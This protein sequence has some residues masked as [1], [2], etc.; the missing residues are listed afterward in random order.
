MNNEEIEWIEPIYNRIEEDVSNVQHNPMITN[1]IGCYNYIDLNRIENDTHYCLNYMLEHNIISTAP[2]MRF[3]TDWTED[4]LVLYSDIKRIIGN[5]DLLRS[6]SNPQIK[7]GL[8][9]IYASA[10]INYLLANAIEKCL[11]IMHD[12][13]ELPINYFYMKLNNGI[14]TTIDRLDGETETINSDE[15]WIAENEIAHITGIAS[16][17]DIQYK[18]FTNWSGNQEDLQYIGNTQ[19]Q[20]T[21]YQGQ[22][23]NVEFTANFRTVFPRTLSLTNAYISVN[24]DDHAESGPR[25]GVY[26]AGDNIM[27][28]ADVAP[29]NKAF[30][31]WEGTPEAL[32]A[33]SAANTDPSTIWLSMPDCDVELYPKYVNAGRHYVNVINGEGSG[34][35]SYDDYVQISATVPNHYGFDNWS[36]D[37]NYLDDIYTPAQSFRIRDE[38]VTL[39]ANYSYRY[40]YNN[41][42]IIDG[43]ISVNG[44]N[45]DKAQS[46]RQ[47]TSYTLVPTLSDDN[48]GL[49]Y[50]SVEGQGSVNRDNAGNCGNTF[51]VGDGNAIVTGHYAP[52]INLT[53][54]NISNTGNSNTYRIVQNHKRVLTTES[55]VGNYRFEGWYEGDTK[56]SSSTSYTIQVGTSDTTIRAEYEYYA[57][58]TVT[59]INRNNGGQTTTSQVLSGNYW[60]TSTNEEVGDHLFVGWNKNGTQVSTSTSY[61][62]YVNADTTIEAVYRAKETYHLTVINGSGSG[63]YKERQSVSITANEGDFSNWSYSNLYSIGNTTSRTTTV[64]LGRNDGIVTAN[65]NMR[66]ITVVTNSGT[67]EYNVVQ[68]TPINVT[69]NPAPS[70]YEFD[71][72][73]VTSGDATIA[74]YLSQSSLVYAHSENSTVEARYK[75]IPWFNINVQNGYVN[76]NDEWVSSGSVLRNSNPAIKMKPASEG[77]QFLQWEVLV[78]N[79][80]DVYQPL[81]EQTTLRNVTHDITVRATYYIPNAD[82]TTYVLTVTQ[83]DG[84]I[85][86]YNNSVG[87]QQSVL[88]QAPDEG[89]RFFRWEGDYQYLVGGRYVS[90]NIVNT[91][92]RNIALQATYIRQGATMTYH[93]YMYGAEC[94]KSR[95]EDPTTHEI[96]EEWVTDGEFEEGTQIEIRHT[97]IP[98]GWRFDAWQGATNEQT[99]TITD[100][101]DETTT[102][103]MPDFDCHITAVIIERDKFTLRIT[104]GELSGEYYEND[105]A[106]VYFKKSNS[107]NEHYSFIRW[108]GDVQYITLYDGGVFD[109]TTPGNIDYPQ[110]IKMPAR[111][112]ELVATYTTTYHLTVSGGTIDSQDDYFTEGA[113]VSITANTIAGKHF[114]RWVG[115]TTGIGSIYDPTTTITIG[116][117]AKSLT[118]VFSNDSDRNN[119]GYGLTSFISSNIINISDITVISGQIAMGFLLSDS[120]GHL[121]IVTNVNADTVNVTRMTK[122][123]KGGGVYE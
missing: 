118:A 110:T 81:A 52:L 69:A 12:Q 88:A 22:Y 25:S 20:T 117:S 31:K 36:I 84:T 122:T 80:D 99:A 119:V 5:V 106:E 72:W 78:G 70:T 91:P 103:T 85:Q 74:N 98:H 58:Y 27:I 73:E 42:Q 30:Y 4:E 38:N 109:V 112:I 115:D 3:K 90:D 54:T 77:Y 35:Y 108:T 40:S 63:D 93:L 102:I 32:E 37:T 123:A 2:V 15:A 113:V 59:Y 94:L 60:S 46:L 82:M 87:Y 39:R 34:W 76:I 56:L 1:P 21:T 6:L 67:T 16:G 45:V 43:L 79:N 26:H 51:T 114:Q 96:I 19:N 68:D 100:I 13:P 44:Q 66:K 104:D 24:G 89:Y 62:F 107:V 121:Y 28:I 75:A 9:E 57:S 17:P 61:G 86:R 101:Y 41:V 47:N 71:R 92:A 65:Y 97:T 49:D 95:T 64:K 23:H 105:P 18:V 111:R 55:V 29:S 83:K 11:F 116:N 7:G 14:I 53:V 8:P 120:Q 10:Q 50:W 33:I 48:T